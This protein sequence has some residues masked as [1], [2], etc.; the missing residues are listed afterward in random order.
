MPKGAAPDKRDLTERNIRMFASEVV[1]A[2]Q[3]LTDKN[4]AGFELTKET[5][6]A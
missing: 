4:Y 5:A 2:L 1:P 3:S 6:L